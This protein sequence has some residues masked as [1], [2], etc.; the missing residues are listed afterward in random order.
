[1]FIQH[2]AAIV[3]LLAICASGEEFSKQNDMQ[4][5]SGVG[6]DNGGDFF[7]LPVGDNDGSD[8]GIFGGFGD[9]GEGTQ[10]FGNDGDFGDFN[11]FGGG[12]DVPSS[13][14]N[15][16]GGIDQTDDFMSAIGECLHFL[17]GSFHLPNL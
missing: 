7:D 4:G 1:M 16:F 2:C 13:G 3:L 12:F 6:G 10:D 11:D 15:P 8:L 17:F 9:G 14:G 5:F